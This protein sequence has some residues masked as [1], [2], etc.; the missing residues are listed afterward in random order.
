MR[1]EDLELVLSWRNLPEVRRNMFT[2]H[3]ISRGEHFAWW[4][5]VKSDPSRRWFLYCQ[6]D[7]PLGIVNYYDLDLASKEGYWGFYMGPMNAL[8]GGNRLSA[9]LDLERETAAYAFGEL[10]LDR[11][12]CETM[13]FNK[14]VLRVHERFGFTLVREFLKAR[15]GEQRPVVLMALERARFL[16]D[17]PE[18]SKAELPVRVAYLGSANW[19]LIAR[20]LAAA[21]PSAG[22]APV[23]IVP[24]PFGQYKTLLADPES[25]LRRA[26]P[27]FTV[28]CERLEDLLET[29][30]SV[31]SPSQRGYLT[32]RVKEYAALI[33]R[34][35]EL[36]PGRFLVLDMAPARPFS[37][38]L[39]DAPYQEES[40]L[41]MVAGL[42]RLLHEAVDG[43]PDCQMIALSGALASFGAAAADPGKYWH[44][45]RMAY[46]GAFGKALN[47][48]IAGAMLA[49]RGRTVR[50]L[51]L[52]L[53][54]TLWGGV[55]GDD[56]MQGIQ[57]GTDYPGNVF[58][59]FQ[60]VLLALKERGIALALCSKNT[61][62]IAMEAIGRL[63]GMRLKPA[64][65]VAWRINWESKAAN[66]AALAEELGLGT[67]SLCFIDDS[68][69]ERDHVRRAY[70]E[71]LVPEMPE[72]VSLWPAF[73][74][75]LPQLAYARL[76]PEDLK[77]AEQ[78]R[79]R[80][81][82]N[83][84]SL[85]FENKEDFWRSLEMKLAFQRLNDLNRKRTVQL[86]AKTNQFNTTTRRHGELDL[87]RIAAAG[88]E[89]VPLALSDKY[90]APEIIGVI[91]LLWPA[92]KREPAEIESFLLSCRVLGR[93]VETGILGWVCA[94]AIARGYA[95]LKASFVETP[96]NQP[97]RGVYPAHGFARD[98]DGNYSLDLATAPV[99]LPPWF[100]VTE[101]P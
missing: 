55:I 13:G 98:S 10:G 68:P 11:L 52:D 77:R 34:A 82:V 54:N 99:A 51:V 22:K 100:Q 32:D 28:F 25:E 65:F 23:A 4:S 8:E 80:A 29:P 14:P 35:R 63:P 56:G 6:G 1:D 19:D 66:I 27:D 101:E 76:T 12:L 81:K 84:D 3:T 41:G 95:R 60:N 93:S 30:F 26:P 91:I 87:A 38:S 2:T 49:A 40:L 94:R 88:G 21:Y 53:D 97:A 72:D 96:R 43:L 24:V 61:E 20:D 45:G 15:D 9:W 59:E 42:N 74:L 33:K 46:N 7:S 36:I 85:S 31:V 67:A 86:L 78:Y 50:A 69:Y 39:L 47:L 58:V 75:S 79:A 57:L 16:A 90:S 5:K 64:D 48:R 18:P 92:D 44:L 89:V 73:I 83:A 17:H 70:P 71:L 37:A 62:A